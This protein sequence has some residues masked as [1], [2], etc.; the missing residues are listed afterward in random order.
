MRVSSIIAIV[1]V[2]LATPILHADDYIKDGKLTHKLKIT[3]L[4][5]G[6]A[7][8]TGIEYTIDPDGAWA[9]AS[10]FNKKLTPKAKG[11]LTAKELESLAA[12]LAKYE[13]AK[14]PAKSGKQPGANPHTITIEFGKH[15]AILVGQ[16]PPKLNKDNP[17]GSVDSRF[18]GI[19]QGVVGLLKAEIKKN[20]DRDK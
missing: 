5:G 17:T 14:L 3:Q 13:L 12:T 6:F 11:D 7:G 4:Q 20:P 2:A 1:L 9:A 8:F 10:V 19:Y 16:T 15:K 18:A